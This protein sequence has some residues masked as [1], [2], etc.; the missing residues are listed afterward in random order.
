MMIAFQD[1]EALVVVT[2]ERFSLWPPGG[3]RQIELGA[4]TAA[5]C[6]VLSL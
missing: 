2:M 1:A 6:A 3:T 5:S 4:G